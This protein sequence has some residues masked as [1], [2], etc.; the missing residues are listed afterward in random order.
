VATG[1]SA[2]YPLTTRLSFLGLRTANDWNGSATRR[3]RRPNRAAD[4]GRIAARRRNPANGRKRR[5]LDVHQGVDEGRV[6]ASFADLRLPTAIRSRRGSDRVHRRRQGAEQTGGCAACHDVAI[7]VRHFP[8]IRLIFLEPI[9]AF[10]AGETAQVAA[11][12]SYLHYTSY[13]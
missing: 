4:M 3:H 7:S 9:P 8:C 2:K 12:P 13:H 5:N 6:V 10:G 1:R 11:L